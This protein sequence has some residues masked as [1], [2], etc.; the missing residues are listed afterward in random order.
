[1]TGLWRFPWWPGK[2]PGGSTDDLLS[3]PIQGDLLGAEHLAERA[4]VLARAQT[5][6]R[7]HP[8]GY[9]ARLLERLDATRRVLAVAFARLSRETATPFRS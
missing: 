3:G 9:R 8:L 6:V 4:R 2:S 1:M 7:T 5:V